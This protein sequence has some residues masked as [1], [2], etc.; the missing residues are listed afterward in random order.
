MDFSAS[1]SLGQPKIG[2][3]FAGS[4]SAYDIEVLYVTDVGLKSL[5]QKY[6]ESAWVI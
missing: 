5:G 1:V 3:V 2:N 6:V 4:I